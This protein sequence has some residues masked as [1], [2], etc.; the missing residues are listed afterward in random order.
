[1]D[2]TPVKPVQQEPPQ[3]QFHEVSLLGTPCHVPADVLD[4][5]R[6]SE[7]LVQQHRDWI[8]L[9]SSGTG[10]PRER[11]EE[12]LRAFQYVVECDRDLLHHCVEH[13]AIHEPQVSEVSQ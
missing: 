3:V 7:Y 6:M 8:A 2:T 10:L 11:I 9:A 5:L 13:F 1:M 4:S 12:L